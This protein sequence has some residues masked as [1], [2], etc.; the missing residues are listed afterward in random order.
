MI[1]SV[2]IPYFA[3]HIARRLNPHSVILP[4]VVG[5]PPQDPERVYAVSPEAAEAGIRLGMSL[6][7]AKTLCPPVHLVPHQ[8]DQYQNF[9]EELLAALVPFTSLVEPDQL[10]VVANLYLDFGRPAINKPVEFVK[11]L[12]QTV[13]KRTGL[14]PALGLAKGKFPAQVAAISVKPSRASIVTPGREATFLAPRT[15]SLLPLDPELAHRFHLLGLRTL[16]QLAALPVGAVLTQFGAHGRWL[17]QLAKGYDD[18]PVKPHC[19]PSKEQVTHQ[20]DDAI[21]NRL[22]LDAQCQVMA[23]ELADQLQANGQV[24]RE[25]RLTLHLEN[26]SE[27]TKSRL[28]RQAAGNAERLGES[29]KLLLDQARIGCSVVGITVRLGELSPV[30]GRQLDLFVFGGEQERR[31]E[32]VLPDLAA[33]YGA[34]RFYQA[35]ITS[36]LAYLPE[37]RFH[38]YPVKSL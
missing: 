36:A 23:A 7:Q 4:L 14:A 25:L 33:R 9:H 5:E 13:R 19:P 10:G 28:L 37:H 34:N 6:R 16:G 31:L 20:F 8:P 3:I 27:W 21:G 29:L 26:G 22:I 12:G 24:G 32:K 35:A 1:A 15:I 18:R 2:Y 17:H 30:S 11:E 38:L